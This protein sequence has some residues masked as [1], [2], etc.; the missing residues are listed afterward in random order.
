MPT[1]LPLLAFALF[2]TA[3]AAGIDTDACAALVPPALA[4]RLNM[5]LPS[6]QPAASSDAGE[7]RVKDIA[8]QGDWPCPFVVVGDF[9]GNGALD[10]AVLLKPREAGNP[11]LIGALNNNGQW[12][13]TLSED[14]P[15]AI[16]DSELRAKEPGLYQRAA[17]IEQPVEQ[18]DQLAS[19]Q[20]DDS[21]FAAG[22][23]GGLHAIYAV[24]SGKW[25][26]LTVQEP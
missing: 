2:Q 22:K 16:G 4:A 8:A 3:A 24:I 7:Q 26:K 6:Y 25:Q 11:R 9:D 1:A 23:V 10:R 17:A 14:W 5:D 19:L 15:L 13:I 12:Q 20:T 21:C 18:F